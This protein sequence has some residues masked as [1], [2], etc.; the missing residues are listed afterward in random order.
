M[1]LREKKYLWSLREVKHTTLNPKG[2]GVVR[3]HLVPPRFDKCDGPSAV[4]LNG[5]DIL[6]LKP[7]WTIMLAEFIDQINK[8]SGHEISE[9][10]LRDIKRNTLSQVK[11]IYRKTSEAVLKK[12]LKTLFKALLDVAY[13][14]IPEVEIPYMSIG[15]YAPYMNAP[16]RM[17]LMVS[18]MTKEGHWHCNQKCKNCYAAGQHHAEVEELTTEQWKTIIDKCRKAYIPQLTFTGGEPTMRNDLVEL[19][20]YAGWFV[21]R[22]NTNGILLSKELCERLY[23]VSLDSV[24]ITLY[25]SEKDEHEALTGSHAFEKTVQGIKN[26]LEAGLNVSVN[27]PICKINKNYVKTLE[28]LHG[29]GV[30]YVSCS[31]II[32]TGNAR[33]EDAKKE[34]LTEDELF[35]VLT[36][37]AAYCQ[38][39]HMEISFT[40]PGLVSEE[41]LEC[42]GVA[43]PTCGACMSNMAIAPNGD[44]VPC[45]SWLDSKA[46]LGNMLTDP[47]GRIWKSPLALSVREFAAKMEESCPLRTGF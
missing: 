44:V 35:R 1:N 30:E 22:L 8:Y 32:F 40:S 28:F 23:D 3:I 45:Q 47:W 5:K 39:N 27:T 6:P 14:N 18:A 11:K 37:A 29:L 26:A 10:D 33:N 24:Q 25:S 21:T 34:Q 42:I 17:D 43:T 31:G 41:K 9:D 13:G 7:A 4:I 36:K 15:E 46:C 2:P 38:E 16:H 20:E 12:D 19:I